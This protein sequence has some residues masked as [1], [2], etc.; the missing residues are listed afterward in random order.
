MLSRNNIV[1]VL[2]AC[3]C[4][5]YKERKKQRWKTQCFGSKKGVEANCKSSEIGFLA[6][7]VM[8]PDKFLQAFYKHT[9]HSHIN[10]VFSCGFHIFIWPKFEVNRNQNGMIL[11]KRMFSFVSNCS[12]ST[13]Y[14]LNRIFCVQ[15]NANF[16][17]KICFSSVP[18]SQ[19]ELFE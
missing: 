6:Q 19:T 9:M 16:T 8:N 5:T 14:E 11:L 3:I 13:K 15:I 12:K 1:I 7:H 18:F 10:C 17:T 2:V 4:H